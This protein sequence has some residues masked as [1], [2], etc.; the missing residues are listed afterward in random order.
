MTCEASVV[1]PT[2]NRRRT[3]AEVLAALDA[4]QS[5][6]PFEIV[7]V[8]DGSTDG[9]AEWLE[10]RGQTRPVRWLRQQNQGPAAARNRGVA[11]ASGEVIA[12]LGDDTI[13]EPDWLA[14]HLARHRARPEAGLAVIGRTTG[15]PRI[16]LIAHSLQER[17]HGVSVT[18]RVST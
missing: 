15:H 7:V 17:F 10:Q 9:T 3:L 16:R 4:Q 6:A 2:F 14:A 13:P 8:D 11:M 18:S 5:V 1:V 12:F